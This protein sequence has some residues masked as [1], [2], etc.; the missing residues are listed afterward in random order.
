M[1]GG[2]GKHVIKSDP[3]EFISNVEN[4]ERRGKRR[5]FLYLLPTGLFYGWKDPIPYLP[6]ELVKSVEIYEG[7]KTKKTFDLVIHASEPYYHS[8]QLTEVPFKG[9]SKQDLEPVKRQAITVVVSQS[10][11]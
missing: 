6:H 5:G 4:S 11:H 8:G 2:H 7:A 1:M 10:S 3:E 9:L